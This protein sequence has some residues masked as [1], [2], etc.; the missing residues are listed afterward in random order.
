MSSGVKPP[1]IWS[2]AQALSETHP[3]ST[4]AGIRCR[5]QKLRASTPPP[6]TMSTSIR[7]SIIPS[8]PA[9]TIRIVGLLFVL[10]ERLREVCQRAENAIHRLAALDNRGAY[11]GTGHGKRSDARATLW[12]RG[13]A[14]LV[15]RQPSNSRRNGSRGGRD[16]RK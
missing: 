8:S 2:N 15:G 11:K 4:R 5:R 9:A 1:P 6:I 3:H 10:R 7:S 13:T 12:E 16:E 14:R